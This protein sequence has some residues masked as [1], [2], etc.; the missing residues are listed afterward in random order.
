MNEAE[1]FLVAELVRR[2]AR[3]ATAESLTA[4]QLAATIANVPGASATLAGGLVSYNNDIKHRLLNVDDALLSTHGAVC[5]DVA[6]QMAEGAAAQ[7][8][9]DYA[10]STTGV[11]GPEP[12]QGKAVGTV[13]IGI[14]TPEG[15]W[16][17]E[18]NF[19]GNR[20][21]I[22]QATVVS[23]LALLVRELT[24]SSSQARL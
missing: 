3:I 19:T 7:F 9:V 14:H 2:G 22:R 5:A 21:Q 13:F 12:H 6:R 4:G 20:D 1:E 17:E 24:G 23:A 8:N 15:S 16:A 11:A 10:L 18:Y